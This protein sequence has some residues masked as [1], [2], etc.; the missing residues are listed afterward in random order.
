MFVFGSLAL[1]LVFCEVW[2]IKI[3][4]K[5]KFFIWQ[6]LLGHMNTLDRLIET[7]AY[8]PILLYSLLEGGGKPDSHALGLS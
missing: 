6:V 4:K 8:G 1:K 3:A 7:Y 5:I 2:R